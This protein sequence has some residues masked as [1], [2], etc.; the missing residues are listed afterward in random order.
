MPSDYETAKKMDEM[1]RSGET[2]FECKNCKLLAA[3]VERLK[4]M[5]D[6]RIAQLEADLKALPVARV[7]INALE[8][9]VERLTERIKTLTGHLDWIGWSSDG[10]DKARA[11]EEEVDRQGKA[12]AQA[13]VDVKRL[14]DEVKQL[15]GVRDAGLNANRSLMADVELFKGTTLEADLERMDA[16]S[17]RDRLLTLLRYTKMKHGQCH[18]R[19]DRACTNCNAVEDLD[20]IVAEW[21]GSAAIP[22]EGRSA[23]G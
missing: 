1:A 6:V 9:E 2:I 20:K 13:L 22:R 14:T 21:K 11:A 4:K 3:E 15:R 5:G 10:I 23:D 19:E 7:R 12:I 17:Q 18:P 8:V 16:E